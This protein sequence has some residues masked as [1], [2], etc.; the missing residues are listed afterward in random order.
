MLCTLTTRLELW[1]RQE[2]V[3]ITSGRLGQLAK[4][5]ILGCFE[6]MYSILIS[7][8]RG[9]PL[10]TEA[11]TVAPLASQRSLQDGKHFGESGYQ[12]VAVERPILF[13]EVHPV[14]NQSS[15]LCKQQLVWTEHTSIDG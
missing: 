7:A 14:G 8:F 10:F 2:G 11:C 6:K 5:C 1:V 15:D 4:C 12:K 13:G 9:T 3:I